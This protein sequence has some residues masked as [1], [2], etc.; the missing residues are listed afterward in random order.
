MKCHTCQ[1]SYIGQSGCRLHSRYKEHTQ[2][3]TTSNPHSMYAHHILS[4][5]HE[6]GPIETII[7]LLHTAQKGKRMNT[8]ENYYI[9]LLSSRQNHQRTDTQRNKSIIW[10]HQ[11]HTT[12][13]HMHIILATPASIAHTVPAWPHYDV[14]HHLDNEGYINYD[15]CFY[16]KFIT[17]IILNALHWT[18][19]KFYFN[20]PTLYCRILNQ[21]YLGSRDLQFYDILHHQ[22]V[23]VIT[24]HIFWIILLILQCMPWWWSAWITE[25]CMHKTKTRM[26]IYTLTVKLL[27]LHTWRK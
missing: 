22:N 4:N 5:V 12:T 3:I 18:Y 24:R 8:L 11:S 23:D 27:V 19:Y 14:H 17:T 1:Q 15:H 20:L 21:F 6:Y 26:F 16:I 13:W 10:T 25:S 2:H 9:Q 7:T